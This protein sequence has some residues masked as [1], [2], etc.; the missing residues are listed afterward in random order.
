MRPKRWPASDRRVTL[1]GPE[2][3]LRA[4]SMG[5]V[6]AA[7][8]NSALCTH[9]NTNGMREAAKTAPLALLDTLLVSS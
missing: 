9:L 8:L 4:V 7:P 6:V 2:R 1:L 3:V 5:I